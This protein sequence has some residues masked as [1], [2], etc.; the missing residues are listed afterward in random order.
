MKTPPNATPIVIHRIRLLHKEIYT[1][2]HA[3]SKRD[4]LGIHAT[5]ELLCIEILALAVKA[6]F[7]SKQIKLGTLESLRVKI[8]MLKHLIRT[9]QE[10]GVLKENTYLHLSAQLVEISKMTNGWIAYTQKGA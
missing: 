6:A 5:V 2:G 8:E 1:I 4:K 9:E 3:L 10:L 7:Q